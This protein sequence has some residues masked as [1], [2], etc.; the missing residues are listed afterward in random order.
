MRLLASWE[1][2]LATTDETGIQIHQYATAEIRHVTAAGPVRLAME[3]DYPWD[4]LVRLMVLETPAAPWSLS[5][6]VPAWSR[7]AT[8]REGQGDPQRVAAG[9]SWES[10]GR[11]WH[12]GDSVELDLDMRPRMTV[13]DPRIDAVRGTVGIERGP[14]VFCVESVDLPAGAALEDV[15]LAP[16]AEP[17]V[18]ERPD[19]G[20]AVPGLNV[21]AIQQSVAS[22]SWPYEPVEPDE[23]RRDATDVDGNRPSTRRRDLELRAIPY[24][25]WANRSVE[26]MRVWIP[27]A[28]DGTGDPST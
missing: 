5:L 13:P 12:A 9:S 1:Q 24:F 8:I 10:R 17:V 28:R 4:G 6:R 11:V 26:A 16:G 21:A 3:T 14:L 25:A 18:V 23:R 27:V 15:Y 7:T 19:V 2:Y 20:D 22:S